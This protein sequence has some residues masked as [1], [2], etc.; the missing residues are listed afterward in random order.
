MRSPI[1][2]PPAP[3]WAEG[4]PEEVVRAVRQEAIRRGVRAIEIVREWTIQ[5]AQSLTSK[6]EKSA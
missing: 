1:A 4:L 3:E 5:A 2:N 6:S